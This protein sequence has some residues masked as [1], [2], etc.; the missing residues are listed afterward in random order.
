MT[1]NKRSS[2]ALFL[3]TRDLRLAD[4]AAFIEAAANSRSLLCLYCVDPGWFSPGRYSIAPMGR[5]RWRFLRESLKD[6]DSALCT[7]KQKLL[8]RYQTPHEAI[9]QLVRAHKIKVV[10]RSA[11]VGYDEIQYWSE[12][13]KRLEG[14]KFVE[15]TTHTLFDQ[16]QL[17]F[18]LNDLPGTFTQF[19]KQVE[20]LP[21][22]GPL[23]TPDILPAPYRGL[24]YDPDLLPPVIVE[25]TPPLT[26]GFH[27]GHAHLDQYF[28]GSL[29]AHYKDVRNELDG[30]DNSSKFSLWL[31]HG[32]LSVREVMAWLDAYK[33]RIVANE[34]TYWLYFELLWREYFQWYAL[35]HGS[36]LFAFEGI[37]NK[38]PL[39]SFYGGRFRQW[40]EGTTP[41]PIVNACM[42]Q[43]KATGYLSN[44]G[45]QLVASCLVHELEIDWR[46]GAAYFEQQLIDYDVASNW[47]NWQYL[48][49][50]GA[51]PRGDRHF[52]LQKQAKQYDPDQRYTDRWD[53]HT[54][55]PLDSVDAA[56]WPIEP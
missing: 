33:E 10:Y 8:V 39:T 7:R 40:C 24:N 25:S 27:A 22:K 52:D 46:Y 5:H 31:A 43:L 32:C 50:V 35:K 54:T 56:D 21:C 49:G 12:L 2:K 11:A 16:D 53:G 45:R 18:A 26:G 55:L 20:S 51:D 9:E 41:Y 37:Q 17:P 29:P 38:R 30:W 19:R 47:G 44:R 36:K 48:A 42:K 6:L 3:F 4:N 14:V 28:S 23:M 15:V 13:Q 1:D 34:S